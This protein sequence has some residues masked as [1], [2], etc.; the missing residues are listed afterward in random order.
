LGIGCRGGDITFHRA[1]VR[2]VTGTGVFSLNPGKKSGATGTS[3][4][5]LNLTAR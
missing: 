3:N 4:G 2:E 1:T 5:R